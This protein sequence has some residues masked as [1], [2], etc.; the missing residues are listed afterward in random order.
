MITILEN[1]ATFEGAAMKQLKDGAIL[2]PHFFFSV[3]NYL[4][5]K[6]GSFK[7]CSGGIKEQ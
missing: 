4:R 6:G 2:A 1:G 3:L 5:S 7:M